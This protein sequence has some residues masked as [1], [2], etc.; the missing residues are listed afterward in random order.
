[1]SISIKSLPSKDKLEKSIREINYFTDK[2]GETFFDELM[3]DN[4]FSYEMA[5]SIIITFDQCSTEE[6]FQAANKMLIAICGYGIDTLIDKVVE[7]DNSNFVWNSVEVN[8]E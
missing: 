4:N 1:M 6:E 5:K 7:R 3:N 2:L 8:N